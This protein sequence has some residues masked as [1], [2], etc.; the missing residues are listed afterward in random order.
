[1]KTIAT[2]FTVILFTSGSFAASNCA[3][4][5]EELKALQTAQQQIMLSLVNNHETFASSMEEYSS[6]VASAKGSSV[7]AVTAQMDE[8]AQ[9]FRT[10]GVQGKKM[11]VKLNAA[12]GDLLARVASC[13]K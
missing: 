11:A 1:M 12:T 2:F 8:S 10:R 9:A 3:Q 13:L 6:V 4:L 5:K 7:N